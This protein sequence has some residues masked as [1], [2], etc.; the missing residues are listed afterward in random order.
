MVKIC[1]GP[2]KGHGELTGHSKRQRVKKRN[3]AG[4]GERGGKKKTA[5][6]TALEIQRSTLRESR[7]SLSSGRFSADT[8]NPVGGIADRR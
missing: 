1:R 5:P 8:S 2:R 6:R 7:A 3:R 4:R